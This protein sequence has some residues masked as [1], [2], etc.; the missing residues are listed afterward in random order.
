V[1]KYVFLL[2]SQLKNAAQDLVYL[3]IWAEFFFVNDFLAS[4]SENEI[5][6][7]LKCSAI[8]S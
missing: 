4:L 2:V 1:Q 8:A 6:T 7:R 5:I 3:A